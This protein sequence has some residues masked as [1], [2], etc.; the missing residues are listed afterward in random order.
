MLSN[1]KILKVFTKNDYMRGMG[2]LNSAYKKEAMANYKKAVEEYN[3]SYKTIVDLSSVLY[4]KRLGAVELIGE[5]ETYINT[6]ANKP[7]QFEKTISD[8]NVNRR[9]FESE[10]Q[11]LEIESKEAINVGGSVAGVG[12]LG[13]VGVAAFGP[14]IAMAVATTFGTASTGT[15]ISAL[16][17]VAATNAALAW[18]GGGALAAGGGGMAAGQAFLALAGP[19]GWAIGGT[20]LVGAGLLLNSKNKKIAE[21]AES[22][23]K[24]VY[25]DRAIFEKMVVKI[26]QLLTQT[27]ECVKNTESR[28]KNM[29]SKPSKDYNSF[30]DLEK[31]D[32][33]SLV[34][35]TET[36]SK[37]INEKIGN[38]ETHCKPI[39]IKSDDTK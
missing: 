27:I 36:L 35:N 9:E 22:K 34:N 21:E 17:G 16:S 28:L 33:E 39:N 15:A 2:M 3:R 38:T 10:I 23:T 25:R 8:I 14:T 7:K 12:V 29:V 18:L 20:A 37:L 1:Y 30:S 19:V 11:K 13:G 24:E 6:I 31:A 4:K 32:F 26:K 5:V